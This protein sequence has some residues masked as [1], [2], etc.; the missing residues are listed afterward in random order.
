MDGLQWKT[1]LKWMIWAPIFGNTHILEWD[2]M[3]RGCSGTDGT[4]R[5]ELPFYL[6][7]RRN[8][9]TAAVARCAGMESLQVA[10]AMMIS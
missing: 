3:G 2:V 9:A 4:P 8:P 5:L 6:E 1:L 7:F 10:Y